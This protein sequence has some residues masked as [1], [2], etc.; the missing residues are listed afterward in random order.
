MIYKVRFSIN[1]SPPTDRLLLRIWP[2]PTSRLLR[3]VQAAMRRQRN[4]RGVQCQC[5]IRR[6]LCERHADRD[7]FDA[8]ANDCA[9]AQLAAHAGG[10]RQSNRISECCEY[11]GN[12]I[13]KFG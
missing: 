6:S 10:D 5:R 8:A 11:A 12:G 7:E 3:P 4:A 13:V 2:R 9:T 1:S